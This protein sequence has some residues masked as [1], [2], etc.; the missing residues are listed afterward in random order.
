MITKTKLKR[1]PNFQLLPI[2]FVLLGS[3]DSSLA[4]EIDEL[5]IEDLFDVKVM[6]LASGVEQHVNKA[7]SVVSVITADEIKAYGATSV[8]QA[9][10]MVPGLHVIPSSFTHMWPVVTFR[11][12]YSDNNAQVLWLMD[13]KR[14]SY[15]VNS[16]TEINFITPVSNIKKIEIVRGPASALYGA[17]AFAGVINLV[18]YGAEDDTVV[19]ANLGSHQQRG[20]SARGSV[21]IS[22]SWD[23]SW[24]GEY[25]DIGRDDSRIIDTD[26]QT[27]FDGIFG[28]NASLAPGALN[29]DMTQ[30]VISLKLQNESWR[31]ASHFFNID[32]PDNTGVANVLNNQSFRE[33]NISRH[34]V[35]YD[36]GDSLSSY[37]IN[38]FINLY[39]SQQQTEL[40]IF[41]ED[42]LLPIGADGNIDVVNTVG[43][44]SFPDGYL[45]FPAGDYE[46]YEFEIPVYQLGLKDHQ[47]RYSL[48][49]RYEKFTSSEVKNF[50]PGVIDGTQPVVDRSFLTDV[51]G[52]DFVYLENQSRR[53]WHASIQDVVKL[54]ESL[55]ATIGLRFDDYSDVGSTVTPRATLVWEVSDKLSTKFLYGSAFRAPSFS[56]RGIR[57]NPA[58]IGNPNLDNETL[59]SYEVSLSYIVNKDIWM[60]LN[61]YFYEADGLI[62]YVAETGQSINNTAQNINKLRGRGL[63]AE[64]FWQVSEQLK[65]DV[66]YAWQSTEN[67]LADQQQ[68]FVPRQQLFFRVNW[69]LN[70]NWEIN[71]A[72]KAILDREREPL[73]MR[74][75]IDDYWLSNL[76]IQY[77]KDN[78]LL[79]VVT[80]NLLDEDIREPAGLGTAI[81]GDFPMRERQGFVEVSFVF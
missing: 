70:D 19:A 68:P 5:S 40:Q 2:L 34:S 73:D 67:N 26:T 36:S 53:V 24:Y 16:G 4:Q 48:G 77:R 79:S 15:S 30:R 55:E 3:P 25:F 32:T 28:T 8:H 18:T 21:E 49:Y 76:N 13:G 52:T 58:S 78:W 66:N 63:E 23:L 43:L 75:Q 51:T 50:G 31:L 33:L 39:S 29:D 56:E 41:P 72:T 61:A 46:V 60:N 27:I 12:I 20:V 11:G 6:D 69:L 10:E 9:L 17:E 14:F 42:T 65:V 38:P 71:L 74:E 64:L 57:N 37:R 22:T 1:I 44:V 35:E 45:G 59:D 47:L 54:S 80:R 81:N 7:P 62:N